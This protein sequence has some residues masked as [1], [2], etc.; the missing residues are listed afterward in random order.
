MFR[1]FHFSPLIETMK[2]TMHYR[3]LQQHRTMPRTY[4]RCATQNLFVVG[5]LVHRTGSY[6]SASRIL[7]ATM[8][9]CMECTKRV[10]KSQS[11]HRRIPDIAAVW[12]PGNKTYGTTIDSYGSHAGA[13]CCGCVRVAYT[14]SAIGHI[15]ASHRTW[16]RSIQIIHRRT[17]YLAGVNR[18]Q[19]G[20]M[21]DAGSSHTAV[22]VL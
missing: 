12:L 1:F 17:L 7:S 21:H 18:Q 9:S 3:N 6:R 20:K 14:G 19:F 5:I 16:R 15:F 22:S 2:N 11:R 10:R 4:S 8:A 13:A